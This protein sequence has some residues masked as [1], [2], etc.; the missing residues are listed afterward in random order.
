MSATGTAHPTDPVGISE[1]MCGSRNTAIDRVPLV[2]AYRSL[3]INTACLVG[4][5]IERSRNSD[6]G[7]ADHQSHRQPTGADGPQAPTFSATTVQTIIDFVP[8]VG[9][10]I[11]A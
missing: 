11:S 7:T 9:L 3:A 10:T 6:Y 2:T 1:R 8:K 4:Q 5:R